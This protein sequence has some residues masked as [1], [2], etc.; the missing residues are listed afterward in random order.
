[1]TTRPI[2]ERFVAVMLAGIATAALILLMHVGSTP[3][4][5]V[6]QLER[7]VIVGKSSMTVAVARRSCEQP[8][9]C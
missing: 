1:M 9:V 8:Q 5:P 7:V 4:R 2:T 3:A 6:M